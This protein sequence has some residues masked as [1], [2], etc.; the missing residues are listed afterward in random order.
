MQLIGWLAYANG[1]LMLINMITLALMFGVNP[2]WGPVNDAFSVLWML[3]FLP[4]AVLLARVNEP[5]L[6]RAVAVG[7]ALVGAAAM[8]LF[9]VL[10]FLLVVRLVRFEQTFAAVVTLGGLLGL[11]L[12]VNGLLALKGKTLPGGLAWS[13]IIFGLSYILGAT[14][15][16]LGG[17]ESPLLWVG[18]ALGYLAGPVWAFWLGWL[19]LHGRLVLAAGLTGRK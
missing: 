17:Y 13:T 16:W 7:T 9:A 18:A 11:W 10:Q 2:F 5:V 4:L 1:V 3:S 14:G 8:L 12:L 15:Y 6:G 19:V